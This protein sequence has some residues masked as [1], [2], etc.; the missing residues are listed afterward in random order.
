MPLSGGQAEFVVQM[1]GQAS[2][3]YLCRIVV[4]ADGKTVETKKKFAIVN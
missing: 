1:T 2:G 4:T 3:V